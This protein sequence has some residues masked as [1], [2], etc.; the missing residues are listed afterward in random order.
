MSERLERLKYAFTVEGETEQWYLLWLRDQINQ[1]EGRKYN[2]AFDV[3]VQ[4]SPRKYYKGINAKTTPEVTHICDV[5]SNNPIHVE[6][7][8]NI[9]SEM[10]EAKSQKKIKYALG[11]S[12]FTFELWMIL[13]KR[14]CNGSLTD[15]RQYL[16][17][18]NQAFGE[19]FENLDQY[20]HEDNFKRCLGK[21]TINDVIMAV[22]RADIITAN[23]IETGKKILTSCRYRYFRDN[24][25]LSIH[26]VV[27]G[28]LTDCKIAEFN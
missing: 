12:N 10:A 23:N 6:K 20:K 16:N 19:K 3:K 4:Q 24:P 2:V 7:F 15:R 28:I 11:Y 18:I 5:E 9:L 26:E 27:K 21:L 8:Q 22:G 13:H 25:S 17:P 1:Y 14:D